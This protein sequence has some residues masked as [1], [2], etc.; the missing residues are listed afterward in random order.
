MDSAGTLLLDLLDLDG[1]WVYLGASLTM[2]NL[3]P[4]KLAL[5]QARITGSKIGGIRMQRE[6]AS[7]SSFAQT[8]R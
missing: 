4:P 3:Q 5:Q 2:I 7:A 8:T 1:T 6:T